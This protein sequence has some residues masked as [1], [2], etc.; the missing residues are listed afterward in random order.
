MTERYPSWAPR[1]RIYMAAPG[2]SD[3]AA[4]QKIREGR[5]HERPEGDPRF[6]WIG[7]WTTHKGTRLMQEW[8]A[9]RAAADGV[10]PRV[11]IA[12][13]G[14]DARLSLP[15]GL[16]DTRRIEMVAEFKRAELPALLARHDAGLFTSIIEGWGLSLQ[17]MLESGLPVFATR[18]GAVPDL[19]PA[20]G[21]L[22]RPFPP[23]TPVPVAAQAQVDWLAYESRFNWRQIARDYEEFVA[24]GVSE[25]PVR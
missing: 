2:D 9:H 21:P 11:T 3:R 25:G 19:E 13:C 14:R 22:L 17:E 18:A 5:S 20:L 15:L 24:G 16:R 1:I 10:E 23:A 6:L 8:M 12:G 7:R 4:L